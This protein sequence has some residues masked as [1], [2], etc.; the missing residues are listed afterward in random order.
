MGLRCRRLLGWACG[1]S[2]RSS[3]SVHENA[4]HDG[5]A[6]LISPSPAA[7]SRHRARFKPHRIRRI[8]K[9]S[10]WQGVRLSLV[11]GLF[12]RL[13]H[14]A[15]RRPVAPVRRLDPGGQHIRRPAPAEFVSTLTI[16]VR[17]CV[18]CGEVAPGSRVRVAG[19]HPFVLPVRAIAGGNFPR[20]LDIPQPAIAG[21]PHHLANF[22]AAVL[23]A[24]PARSSAA[25]DRGVFQATVSAPTLAPSMGG[26]ATRHTRR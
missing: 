21:R 3:V 13:E 17:A 6:A 26:T 8:G 4:T 12:V 11:R 15:R 24:M 23:S 25:R 18:E 19:A 14:A 1:D 5:R 16:P 7:Q 2:S 22:I 9:F 20:A 10:P